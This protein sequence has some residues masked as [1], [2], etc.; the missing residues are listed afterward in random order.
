MP[1]APITVNH[2]IIT[3]PKSRPTL[4]VPNFWVAKRS[5]MITAVTGTTKRSKDGSTSSMPSTADSTETAGVIMPSPKKSDAPK[6][7][8]AGQDHLGARGPAGRLR[9]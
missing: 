2:T 5:T 4:A 6:M 8:S 7:P 1:Q 3:G 9:G